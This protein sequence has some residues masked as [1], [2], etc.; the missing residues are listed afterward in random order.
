MHN[1]LAVM[2]RE[3][4]IRLTSLTWMLF[5][6]AVPMFYLLLFGI[7]FNK[8]LP[9]GISIDGQAVSYNAFFLA[10][11]ISMSGFG[12]GLNTS[13]GFFMDR[14]NGIFYE[15]LTYP[16]TRG[17]FLVGKILFSS[18]ITS[19]QAL[20]TIAIGVLLLDVQLAFELIPVLLLANIVSTAGWFFFLTIIALRITRNDYYNSVSNVLYF[21]LLFAS[22]IFFP[23]EHSPAWLRLIARANPLTWSTDVLRHVSIGT[24][25]TATVY[26]E[27]FC[28]VVFTCLAFLVGI[29]SLNAAE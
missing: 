22:S 3:Y 14:D 9:G 4:R 5:D 8:A 28:F 2:Y 24:G 12:L 6:L 1:I 23:I 27:A 10:G 29:R 20:L 11:V 21:V 15:L 13:Y 7:G 25:D 26:I 17:E 16:M 19:V 18:L